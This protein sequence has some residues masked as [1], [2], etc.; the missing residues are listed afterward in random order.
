MVLNQLLFILFGIVLDNNNVITL[1]EPKYETIR[2]LNYSLWSSLAFYS[3]IYYDYLSY[4]NAYV[5]ITNTIIGNYIYEL[6]F[7]PPDIGHICH[8]ICTIAAMSIGYAS[9]IY[10]Y[11]W[12]QHLS[13]IN[14]LAL[15]SSFFSSMRHIN[16]F[17]MYKYKIVWF[18]K[19]YYVCS[20]SMAMVF[21][22]WILYNNWSSTLTFLENITVCIFFTVHLTQIYFILKILNN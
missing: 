19:C 11:S 6:T 3:L 2:M 16:Y 14:Y 13:L 12:A 4:M 5:F 20:K 15:S 7:H 22:Y 1:P 21:H 8:H 9:N 10:T 17:K 18:Y